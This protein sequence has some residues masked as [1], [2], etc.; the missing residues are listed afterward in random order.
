MVNSAITPPSPPAP[1]VYLLVVLLVSFT[2]LL[3]VARRCR[4]T[5]LQPP[6][7]HSCASFSS[8]KCRG[9][10]GGRSFSVQ[11]GFQVQLTCP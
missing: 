2:F 5:R 3:G 6:G 8:Y 9:G 10:E 11:R 1:N 7:R 4:W